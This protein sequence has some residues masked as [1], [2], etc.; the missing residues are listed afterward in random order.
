VDRLFDTV[1]DH[2]RREA[3]NYFEHRDGT[4]TRDELVDHVA[5]R[6][7]HLEREEVEALLWHRH[8]PRLRENG[9]LEVDYRTDTIR[10]Q[11]HESA[12]QWTRKMHRVVAGED[13]AT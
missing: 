11:G 1:S 8:L 5:S 13:D 7:P 12:A 10:Y 9:W 4:A 6:V 3:I 2:L